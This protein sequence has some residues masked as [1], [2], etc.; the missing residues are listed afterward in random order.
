MDDTVSTIAVSESLAHSQRSDQRRASNARREP[1]L[2]RGAALLACFDSLAAVAAILAVLIT[3]SRPFRSGAL[4]DFL[5]ARVTVKNVLLLVVLATAW[6]LVL[7]LFGLYDRRHLRHAGNEALRLL[8]ATTVGTG[9]AL[10][11]PLTSVSGVVAVGDVRHFWIVSFSL[12]LLVRTG[13]RALSHAQHRHVRRTLILGTGRM[14]QGVCRDLLSDQTHRHEFVGFVDEAAAEAPGSEQVQ[15]QI[16]GALEDLELLLMRQVIDEVVIALP[17]AS[18]YRQIQQALNVC[19]RAGVR[20]RYAV[21]LFESRVASQRYDDSGARGFVAMHVA[22]DGYRLIVKRGIDLVGAVVGL[23]VFSPLMLA[24]AIAIKLTSEGP[25]L[26]AQERCGLQKRPL[27]MY[28]FRSMLA[29]ADQRQDSLEDQN[30]ASGPVFKIRDDPRITPFG[31]VLRRS[32]LDELPQLWNVL[33]GDMSLV[34]PRPLPWRDVNR[35]I[36]P[37]DMRRFSMRPGLTCLWQV[38]GRSKLSFE[39][40]VELDLVYIDNW[41]L[42]LDAKILVQTIPAVVTANGAT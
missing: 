28:K 16:V 12:C 22:P 2:V 6:P 35:I 18:R 10:L 4:E 38:Q 3:V 37:S 7:Y 14:A 23:V 1:S 19:E 40:W 26:Y 5:S 11:F 25:V 8:G 36:N 34:G 32:S 29:D 17:V 41:S 13:R 33:T 21:D 9:L 30:E 24:I 27:R 39:R 20:A 42:L 31:R 15:H